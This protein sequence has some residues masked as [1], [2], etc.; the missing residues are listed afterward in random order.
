MELRKIKWGIIGLG[1]IANQFATDL[2]LVEDAEL[3]AVASRN[4]DNA[5]DFASRHNCPKAYDSYEAL[6]A[7]AEVDIVYIATPHNSHAELSIKTLQ[8][9]KHVLCEK[10]I[11]LSYDDAIRMI[12]ASGKHNKFF[13]EAFWTRFIPSVQD[14][15]SKV[16]N[17]EIGK[18]NYIKADFAFIG[19]E[20]E[21]SRLFDKKSGGGA[22]FDIGVYPLFL[23]YIMLGIPKEIIA[24]SIFHKNDIDLQ[25]SMLLQY[26]D[27]QAVLHASIVS[28]SDMKAVIGGTKGRIELNSPWFMADGYSII[29][30]EKENT[31]SLPNLGKGYAHEA[32]ECHKCIRNNQIESEL[33]SHQNSLDLSKIVEEI[34]NQ[35]GLDFK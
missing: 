15:L 28:E 9:G 1:N 4:Y 19:N 20:T 3:V 6:F 35:I 29:K 25:T 23:S 2:L 24:K 34:R 11:A 32:I 12:E 22:L 18:V 10:P 33:W 21:G 13:M 27:A 26:D 17:G 16:E 5:N 8:N 14:V 30:D 7:D 31:F